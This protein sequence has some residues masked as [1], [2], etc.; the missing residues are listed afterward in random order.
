MPFKALTIGALAER[1]GVSVRTLQYYDRIGLLRASTSEGG[2]RTYAPGDIAK[3]Q[4]I[5]FLKSFGLSLEEIA[6]S[7]SD[8]QSPEDLAAV[9][10]RQRDL[11]GKQVAN[12]N[13]VIGNLDSVIAQLRGGQEV[14]L[15]R[16]VA[17]ME[18]MRRGHPYAFVASYFDD[19]QY[20]GIVERF[21]GSRAAED[22]LP[23]SQETF[24]QLEALHRAGADPEGPAGQELAARWWD[25]V[26]EFT[27]PDPS[28]LRSMISAGMDVD[29][30]PETP[31]IS[32][33]AIRD[34]LGKALDRYLR[35][36]GI[37]LPEEEASDHD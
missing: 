31:G 13:Q 29:R 22:F 30:W 3:L 32:R 8:R 10:M 5:L 27:K 7:V 4:Q 23:R 14:S 21:A 1:A 26:Q 18:L 12:L 17:I 16:L 25:L 36:H 6:D 15:D 20:R 2:R 34:F 33:E 24:T 35:D 11:L 28:L 9:F 19:R 37:H